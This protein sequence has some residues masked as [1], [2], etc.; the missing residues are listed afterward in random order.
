MADNENE[1]NLTDSAIMSDSGVH[2]STPVSTSINKSNDEVMDFL[3]ELMGEM[4]QQ[5]AS[6]RDEMKEQLDKCFNDLIIYCV[7]AF[8]LLVMILKNQLRSEKEGQVNVMRTKTT[9]LWTL[10]WVVLV[11]VIIIII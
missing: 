9:R 6:L 7:S 5:N 8:T 10:R 11:K 3:G 1:F 4:K 2:L